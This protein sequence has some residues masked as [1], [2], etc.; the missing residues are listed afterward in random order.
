MAVSATR[1]MRGAHG[2]GAGKLCHRPGVS[3]TEEN[4]ALEFLTRA[5]A[6]ADVRHLGLH[7]VL[8]LGG[9]DSLFRGELG[10]LLWQA[11]QEGADVFGVAMR[12]VQ[13]RVVHVELQGVAN[14]AIFC[15]GNFQIINTGGI[16]FVAIG[17]GKFVAVHRRNV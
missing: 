9:S 14:L 3:V 8:Q 11:A 4:P 12:Q 17:A 10:V 5:V 1:E 15:E 2:A 16:G 6:F 7:E 13:I